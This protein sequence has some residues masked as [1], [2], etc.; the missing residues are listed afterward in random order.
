MFITKSV[1]IK[2]T[3]NNIKSLKIHHPEI[4]KGDI[5][6]IDTKHLSKGSHLK[7]EFKCDNCDNEKTIIYKD[8]IRFNDVDN[9]YIGYYICPNCK[10]VK[11]TQKSYG[12]DNV[13]Q[14][15]DTKKKKEETNL[16]NCG[17]RFNSQTQEYLDKCISTNLKK[18]GVEWT[19]QN[20]KIRAKQIAT[21]L[22]N[23]GVDN[24]S[25]SD[26]IKDKIRKSNIETKHEVTLKSDNNIIDI[27]ADNNYL[28]K[29]ES[30]HDFTINRVLYYKR[31]ETNTTICTKCNPISK[32]ISGL[33]I[34]LYN[35]IK[36]VYNGT[37]YQNVKN[38]INPYELDIYIPDLSLA[39]EF[40]GL[41]WH[42]ELNKPSNYHKMKT[43]MCIEQ[44]IQLLHIWEDDWV[45][46]QDLVKS[47]IVNKLGLTP[48]KI[49]AR[50]CDTRLITDIKQT[51][52]FLERN[53][54]Q[55]FV[56]ST[57]KIGLFYNDELVSISLY[58]KNE[59]NYELVR[60]CNKASYIV[61]GGASK[62]FKFFL[63]NY[64][65][66]IVT[67][68]AD[69]TYSNGNLYEKLGFDIVHKTK[70]NYY[71]IVDGIRRHKSNFK[72]QKLI[73]EGFDPNKSEHEIMLERKMYRIYNSGNIKYKFSNK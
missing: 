38:I 12:V 67:T 45:Y 36:S 24:P 7:I 15:T 69:Y 22:K 44:N 32:N 9:D 21:S 29:C 19:A 72:K 65:P 26:K 37:I 70:P 47:M 10:R 61:I 5:I 48:Y 53:H 14:L 8:Y 27:L 30:G 46:K 64:K 1:K 55:G 60:F 2:V 58:N 43:D 68:F 25:K 20:D 6:S 31:R 34:G 18:F 23:H 66:N 41:Y 63:K 57:L 73:K 40:N 33:E 56:K 11:S 35:F 17:K 28:M 3:W 13:S 4:N 49:F 50:K 59:Q 52:D 42:N 71:Y 62:L 16:K 39:L 54:I 51:K